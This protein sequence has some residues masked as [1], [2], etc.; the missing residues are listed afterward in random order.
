MNDHRVAVHL[1]Q[2]AMLVRLECLDCA[3]MHL[4]HVARRMDSAVAGGNRAEAARLLGIGR[5]NLYAKM[6]EL[7]LALP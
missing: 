1:P 2:R 4:G 5:P 6:K 3:R 7:G